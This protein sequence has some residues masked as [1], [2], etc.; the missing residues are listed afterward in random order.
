MEAKGK[1]RGRG[2]KGAEEEEEAVKFVEELFEEPEASADEAD[3]GAEKAAKRGK[4]K[5]AAKAK[6]AA[7]ASPSKARP[8]P[9]KA[10]GK[11]RD[12]PA[13]DAIFGAPPPSPCAAHSCSERVKLPNAATVAIVNEWV[14]AYR[15]DPRALTCDL[16]NFVLHAAGSPGT[17][18][19]ARFEGGDISAVIE[20][21]AGDAA[22][23]AEGGE[24]PL[25]ARA[26]ALKRFRAN[27]ADFW[28]KLILAC[29]RTWL[30]DDYFIE[31]L[32]AWLTEI[33]A[34]AVPCPSPLAPDPPQVVVPPVSPRRHGRGLGNRGRPLGGASLR[35]LLCRVATSQ[36]RLTAW[37]VSAA[38]SKERKVAAAQL[39]TEK[40][41]KNDTAAQLE[42]QVGELSAKLDK[43][44]STIGSLFTSIFVHRYRDTGADI[45]VASI[46][47]LGRW[48]LLYP[49]HWLDDAHLKYLA[50][51]LYDR[52]PEVRTAA[53]RAFGDLYAECVRD[54]ETDEEKAR[55]KLF[56][57]GVAAVTER[58]KDRLVGMAYD[59]DAAVAAVAVDVCQRMRQLELLDEADVERLVA[60]VS[61]D[62]AA[63]RE[64]VGKF[65]AEQLRGDRARQS[66]AEA[67]RVLVAFVVE[68]VRLPECPNYV[69]D[70]LWDTPYAPVRDWAAMAEL[71]AEQGSGALKG[72]EQGA[73]VRTLV[74]SVKKAMGVAV[75]P[76]EK[77]ERPEKAATREANQRELT[78]T[79]MKPLPELL[80]AFQAD[81]AVVA[82]L[83]QLVQYF[84]LEDFR[85]SRQMS[86]AK[87]LLR[88]LREVFFL[89]TDADVHAAVGGAF[90]ALLAAESSVY[91]DVDVAFHELGQLLYDKLEASLA[92]VL[93]GQRDAQT[94][95]DGHQYSLEL[96]LQRLHALLLSLRV[97]HADFAD[98][99]QRVMEARTHKALQKHA[100]ASAI[101]AL[102]V[103][104]Q[105]LMLQW[106][107]A[108]LGDEPAADR[109]KLHAV[110][111]RRDRYLE[112]L[113]R[114]V[115]AGA[116]E[117]RTE[118]YFALLDT[119]V[120]FSPAMRGTT[121]EPLVYEADGDVNTAVQEAFRAVMAQ[122]ADGRAEEELL[123]L[124]ERALLALSRGLLF[125]TLNEA[126]AAQVV[127]QLTR[128]EKPLADIARAFISQWRER[129]A[130]R[131]DHD[132][133]FEAIRAAFEAATA[134]PDA[135]AD[136][137]RRYV[138]LCSR[139][140]A[141]Y[142]VAAA[143]SLRDSLLR[144]IR[145]VILYGLQQPEHLDVL[146]GVAALAARL[147]ST[148]DA[149]FALRTLDEA[150]RK[151]DVEPDEDNPAHRPLIALRTLLDRRARGVKGA[152][153]AEEEAAA[154]AAKAKK[155]AAKD[156]KKKRNTL[157]LV[158]V[159]AEAEEAEDQAKR[160]KSD[161]AKE[162]KKSPKA[163]Q[164]EDK[165]DK[166]ETKAKKPRKKAEAEE[167][168]AASGSESGGEG[169]KAQA[170][171]KRTKKG[172]K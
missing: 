103:K 89:H 46:A 153:A 167:E 10:K 9:P 33:S 168:A 155:S 106:D 25:V 55:R 45:R 85:G 41:K 78:R 5:K 164:S 124:Q 136:S 162:D 44:K 1:G 61:D 130:G 77:A 62:S 114:V 159:H 43:L 48:E 52:A 81:G 71:L 12:E 54:A 83:V 37:Q 134:A 129:K 90:R 135:D 150:A 49:E 18:S 53:L 95:D 51:S 38:L 34:Y 57:D 161:K 4:A 160:R 86:I 63:L 80:R 91:S 50:W 64:A 32:D 152:A 138:L 21:L 123:E 19:G 132:V 47:A 102:A 141:V 111:E 13:E 70:A 131:R 59:K 39:A 74:C 117:Q 27:Y 126:A 151:A 137:E 14:K 122:D 8:E 119:L 112:Q 29:A 104:A 127:L 88:L 22:Y 82:E 144:L 110:V 121:A 98:A 116:A 133:F 109:K 154:G 58:Y 56:G 170:K 107:V 30:F 157:E 156:A 20:E 145:A 28:N 84:P 76:K 79:L 35:L 166:A 92:A 72:S 3:E 69:V 139:I 17:V 31:E 118:A 87:E 36:A 148:D 40:K 93:K 68:R 105:A 147:A 66:K 16:I 26:K 42:A 140:A 142:G 169:K 163:R 158:P 24:Y 75:V 65:L 11:R 172:D 7:P 100:A 94:D 149:Q 108:G 23:K 120:V 15:K 73:L 99:L 60:L 96:S 165:E 146:D 143:R 97:P 125:N 67:V 115:S 113:K 128:D 101:V 2:R 6:E 171:K